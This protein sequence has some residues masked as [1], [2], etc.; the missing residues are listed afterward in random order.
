MG[1]V[2]FDPQRAVADIFNSAVASWA[3]GAAWELGLLDEIRD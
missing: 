2:D 3:I 1:S